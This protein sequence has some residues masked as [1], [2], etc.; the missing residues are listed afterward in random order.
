[1]N[2]RFTFHKKEH[3]CLSKQIDSLFEHGRWLRSQHLRLIYQFVDDQLPV[4]AQILFAVPK[5]LHRKAVKR[6]LLKRRMRESYRKQKHLIYNALESKNTYLSIGLVYS[7][8]E[9]ADYQH[10]NKEIKLLLA[11]L[12]SRLEREITL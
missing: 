11:Q 7:S 3:L 6:N 12:I 5:K 8:E 2:T 9:I 10:I 1:M 4:N